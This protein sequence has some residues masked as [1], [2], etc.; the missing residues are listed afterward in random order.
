MSP[1]DL[2]ALADRITSSLRLT[3]TLLQKLHDG[4][5]ARR[6][7]WIAARP[8]TM[9]EPAEALAQLAKDLAAESARLQEHYAAAKELL[10]YTAAE[11]Q[12]L[13]VD[14]SLIAQHL[15]P[16]TAAR[17][18]Q[19]AGLATDG[20]RRVR[21]EHALGERLLRFS[22]HTHESL[23]A[24]VAHALTNK[25]LDVGGYDRSARR[26]ADSLRAGATPGSLVDGRM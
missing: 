3:A 13:H 12:H 22:Q 10:P 15:P 19:A 11:R 16:T 20:A 1:F 18:R 21:V 6:T 5:R 26:V 14:A 9:Q 25:A 4:L 17:L 2:T 24:N 8:S 23:M 7:A